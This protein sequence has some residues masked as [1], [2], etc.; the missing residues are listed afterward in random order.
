M[1]GEYGGAGSVQ[2]VGRYGGG[3]GVWGVLK[4]VA[5]GVGKCV[6]VWGKVRGNRG[7]VW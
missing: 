4:N 3:I 5:R 2:G 1:W 6:G 7:E